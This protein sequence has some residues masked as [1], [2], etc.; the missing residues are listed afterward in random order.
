MPIVR[1]VTAWFRITPNREAVIENI[2]TCTERGA[3]NEK[4]EVGDP[5]LNEEEKKE[6]ARQWYAERKSRKYRINNRI[7]RG[8]W[9]WFAGKVNEDT[10]IEGLEN[11]KAI[12]GGAVVTSNH[13]NPL[14]NTAVLYMLRKAGKKHLYAVS[15]ETNFAMD[16]FLGYF[17]KY[18]DTIPITSDRK[19]M[20]KEFYVCLEELIAQGENI[21]IYPE[22][23]M[24]FNYRKPRPPKRGAYYYAARLK[25]PIL[26]CFVEIRDCPEIESGNFHRVR[27]VVHVL[28][29]IFPDPEKTVRENSYNMM[30]RD[31]AQKKAAYEKAY[32]K[33]LVYDFSNEDIAGWIPENQES[34]QQ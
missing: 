2:K 18:A 19:V 12:S 9:T 5:P 32:G 26:S 10:Q 34:T 27:Y 17:M 11:A 14:D 28:P 4:V 22:Q 15:Q 1:K 3:F 30:N 16:G 21:L 8:L 20:E 6:V 24:W 13:F 33:P 7:S 23:E 25:A 29:P 31:Y